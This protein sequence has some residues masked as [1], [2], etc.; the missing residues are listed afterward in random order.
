MILEH[1]KNVF[2]LKRNI[3][4][5]KINVGYFLKLFFWQAVL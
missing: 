4:E 1:A 5:K 3:A 2:L